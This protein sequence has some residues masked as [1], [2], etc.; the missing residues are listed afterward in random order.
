MDARKLETTRDTAL[1]YVQRCT[2][3]CPSSA[4]CRFRRARRKLREGGRPCTREV[5]RYKRF[6]LEVTQG[7]TAF[8]LLQAAMDAALLDLL[9]DRCARRLAVSPAFVEEANKANRPGPGAEARLRPEV[10]M[11]MR[12]IR[13]KNK[14]IDKCRALRQDATNASPPEEVPSLC[15]LNARMW[16]GQDIHDAVKQCN[17]DLPDDWCFPGQS[18]YIRPKPESENGDEKGDS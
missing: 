14:L 18:Q 15:E 5:L 11:L 13:R 7:Q 6:V 9:V 12:L 17:P 8:D 10:N 3:A 4:S 1:K 2:P 16:G